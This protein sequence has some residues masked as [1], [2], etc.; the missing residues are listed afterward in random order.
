MRH[1]ISPP[2]LRRLRA[3]QLTASIMQELNP[4]LRDDQRRDVHEAVYSLLWRSGA[5]VL[6]D[7]ARREAGLPDRNNEGWTADELRVLEAK[8]LEVLL[9]PVPPLLMATDSTGGEAR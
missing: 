3:Q 8:R 6:T 1:R 7:S 2:D 4:L 9:G 5:E